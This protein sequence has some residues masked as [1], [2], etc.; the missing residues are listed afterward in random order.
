MDPAWIPLLT[1]VALITAT[2]SS[3]VG[4]GGGMVLLIVFYLVGLSPEL[5]IPLHGCVQLVANAS[6]IWVFREHARWRPF[7]L[8]ALVSAPLPALGMLLFKELPKDTVKL[9][10]G[11]FVLYATW[12]PRWGV[13]AL[14]ERASMAAAGAVGGTF[15]VVVGAN[16]PLIAPFLLNGPY[17]KEELV[18]M[19]AMCASWLHIIKIVAFSAMAAFSLPEHATSIAPLTVA[20]IAGAYIGRAL[21]R[22]ISERSFRTAFKVVLTILAV[23]LVLTPWL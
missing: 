20:V 1:V 19:H 14:G 3:V 15:G 12:M 16:G 6:R 17:K 5:A 7:V 10:F 13:R 11:I 2:I 9:A 22:R 21:L 23:R 8:F 18:A 4:L